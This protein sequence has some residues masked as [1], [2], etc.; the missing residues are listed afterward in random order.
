MEVLTAEYEGRLLTT[1]IECEVVS[2]LDNFVVGS[3]GYSRGAK[4][5]DPGWFIIN[6]QMYRRVSPATG[7][8]QAQPQLD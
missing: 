7:Q 5:G 4:S 1:D 6:S 3:I 2:S 8:W